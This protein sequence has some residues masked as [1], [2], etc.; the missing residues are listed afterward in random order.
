MSTHENEVY[1]HNKYEQFKSSESGFDRAVI[2]HELKNFGL[3]EAAEEMIEDWWE[4]RA[5]YFEDRGIKTTDVFGDEDGFE[6]YMDVIDHGDQGD[7]YQVDTKK[8]QV[9]DYL[10]VEYWS[11]YALTP[12]KKA[13]VEEG[14]FCAC[15]DPSC[16]KK[17]VEGEIA[18]HIDQCSCGD[19]HRA[20]GKISS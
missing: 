10:N 4:E 2:L 14:I 11:K 9:P 7:G 5:K 13:E 12:K 18:G 8:V 16:E 20:L 6:Y 19:C 17:G 15:D 3:D 1:L